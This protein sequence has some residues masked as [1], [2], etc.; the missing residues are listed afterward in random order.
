MRLYGLLLLSLS[1]W[2]SHSV[3]KIPLK[4]FAG[5]FNATAQLDLRPLRR[6]EGAVE[7]GLSL[8][9]D[10]AGIVNFLDMI[11]NLKG[12]S[13]RGYYMQMVIGT[14]GQTT[15]V[16]LRGTDIVHPFKSSSGPVRRQCKRKAQESEV[17]AVLRKAL[18]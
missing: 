3:F 17:T 7:S 14:P 6:D 13:G 8:A 18:I 9:S 5:N 10:P 1:F 12:D 2:T 16:N 15:C 11:S 4:I